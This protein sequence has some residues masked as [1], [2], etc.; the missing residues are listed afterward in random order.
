MQ[1]SISGQDIGRTPVCPT[2]NAQKTENCLPSYLIADII[3]Q[4]SFPLETSAGSSP[5]CRA[6]EKASAWCLPVQKFTPH[7]RQ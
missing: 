2:E 5:A 1:V 7:E 4:S 3:D 6:H